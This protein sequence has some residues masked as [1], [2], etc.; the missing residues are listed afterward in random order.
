M[1]AFGRKKITKLGCEKYFLQGHE[2]SAP[3][4]MLLVIPKE[5]GASKFN[6][7]ES[8]FT[9]AKLKLVSEICSFLVGCTRQGSFE[10]NFPE[11][12]ELRNEYA[13]YISCCAFCNIVTQWFS[14]FKQFQQIS[15]KILFF[16]SFRPFCAN[17]FVPNISHRGTAYNNINKYIYALFR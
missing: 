16:F 11:L 3:L 7:I 4:E 13:K 5:K 15:I 1:G 9:E 8:R 6:V 17:Y 10:S 14:I 2:L 12:Q